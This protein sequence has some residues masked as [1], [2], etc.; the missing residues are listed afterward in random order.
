VS[1]A[2]NSFFVTRWVLFLLRRL[3]FFSYGIL[4]FISK[5]GSR[6][7]VPVVVAV[8]MFLAHVTLEKRLIPVIGPTADLV[9]QIAYAIIHGEPTIAEKARR[10]TVRA[11]YGYDIN[12]WSLDA[13]LVVIFL[14]FVAVYFVLSLVLSVVLGAF[15]KVTRPLRPLRRLEATKQDVRS[16]KVQSAVPKLRRPS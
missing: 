4:Q 1:A 16:A 6:W 13:A 5:P 7:I 12:E 8:V 10:A 11:Y 9:S 2:Y 15:P 3:I 14:L